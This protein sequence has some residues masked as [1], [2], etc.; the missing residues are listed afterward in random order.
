M[1]PEGGVGWLPATMLGPTVSLGPGSMV[2]G[3][4][5]CAAKQI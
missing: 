5:Q 2:L 1:R 4:C 3:Q